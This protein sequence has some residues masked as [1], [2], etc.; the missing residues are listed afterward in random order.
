MSRG[1]GTRRNWAREDIGRGR[2]AGIAAEMQGRASARRK[3]RGKEDT[4]EG[5]RGVLGRLAPTHLSRRSL[6]VACSPA[7]AGGRRRPRTRRTNRREG[8]SRTGASRS[9]HRP[10]HS[11]TPSSRVELRRVRREIAKQRRHLC[12]MEDEYRPR[13]SA[14]AATAVGHRN[15]TV[16]HAPLEGDPK[17]AACADRT[18]RAL[19]GYFRACVRGRHCLWR[20]RRR[21]ASR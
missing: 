4:K 20:V 16:G 18:S 8:Q 5:R 6:T 3:G 10:G 17:R 14:W 19:D 15:K 12:Q 21:W 9:V 1:R 11:S 13:R 2:E 7:L